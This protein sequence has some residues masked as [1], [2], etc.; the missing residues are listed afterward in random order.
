MD[1]IEM[2]GGAPTPIPWGEL[3]TSLQQ[4]MVDG[5]ENNPPSFYSNRHFEVCKHLSMDEHTRIPDILLMSE[6]IWNA[7]DPQI[8]QWVQQA[9]DASAIYQR[10]LWKEKTAESLMEVQK[11]ENGVT[12]YYPDK[13]PF[14]DAVEPMHK[15]YDNTPV[16][17]F[18][19]RIK[20]TE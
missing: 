17:E 11:E 13:K 6:K 12:V 5:A 14:M 8:Q 3:Y 2:L 9:A 20:N 7:L 19:S 18:L 4:K 1:M 16:G 15:K 10:K